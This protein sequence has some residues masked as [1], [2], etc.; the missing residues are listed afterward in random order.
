M[1]FGLATA[2]EAWWWIVPG[3]V[4]MLVMFLGASIPFMDNRNLQRKPA[5]TEYMRRTSALLSLPPRG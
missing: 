4:T 3:A 2:P 1:L 5:C